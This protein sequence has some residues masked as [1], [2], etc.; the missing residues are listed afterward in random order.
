MKI[1]VIGTVFLLLFIYSGVACAEELSCESNYG[2]CTIT[3]T[4][5]EC[6]CAGGDIAD[7]GIA[8]SGT[9]GE[10][11]TQEVSEEACLALLEEI[12]R[13]STPLDSC[14]SEYGACVIYEDHNTCECADGSGDGSSSE[15]GSSGEGSGGSADAEAEIPP[16][17]GKIM[18]LDEKTAVCT[19]VLAIECPNL[20]PDPATECSIEELDVCV[21]MAQFTGECWEDKIWPYEIIDCCNEYRSSPDALDTM[22]ECFQN[23]SCDSVAEDCY[24]DIRE[25]NVGFVDES[26]A[27]G[28]EDGAGGNEDE[29]SADDEDSGCSQTGGT[30]PFALLLLGLIAIKKHAVRF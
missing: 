9:V 5:T 13:S 7:G 22:W 29:E 2:E 1:I 10:G 25:A 26:Q 27:L 23:S 11:E 3:E 6:A 19:D 28:G 4:T 21:G 8:T 14:E 17:S 18:P 15:P 24:D 16:Q 20:P 12:C 30:M